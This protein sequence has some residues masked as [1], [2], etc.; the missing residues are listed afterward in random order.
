[1]K[2]HDFIMVVVDK[3]N[4]EVNF[5]LVKT[6][7]KASNIAKIYM[8]EV[9]RL[10][11]VPKAI[12]S[13]RDPM[14]TSNFWKGLF[15][16]FGTN[17]NLSILYH[18]ESNG[19]TERTNGIIE[20]MLRMCVMDQ[21]SKWEYYIHLVEFSYNNGYRASLKMIPFESLYGRECNTPV[22]WDNPTDRA[23]IWPYLL[24]EMEEHMEKIKQNLKVA[25]DRK[26]NYAEKNGVFRYFK[27]GEHVFLKIKTKRSSL[28]L[29]SFPMLAAR[30]C[31]PFEILEKIGPVAYMLALPSS[32]RMHNVF[33]VSLLKKYVPDP[34]HIID[35]NV[36]Q[37]EH[38]GEFRVEVVHILEW[39]LNVLRNKAIGLVKVQWTCYS[40]KDA[41]WENEENMRE[42]YPQIFDNFEENMWEEYLQIFYNFEEN[43]MRDSILSN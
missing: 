25:Q 43:K 15:K 29:G 8:K 1:M 3:L 11:G 33:Y 37:V 6:T 9:V 16:F 36:I 13:Y 18:S 40:P 34:N 27:V 30:Y 42:E 5:I 38:E 12:V 41:T 28:R 31:G 10:H 21:P 35:W 32:I 39:K 19:K 14:F 22:I 7:H 17:L 26:K 23:V 24:K 4:K 2:Q 20:D